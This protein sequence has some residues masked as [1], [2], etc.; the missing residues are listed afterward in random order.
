LEQLTSE[1]QQGLETL[2]DIPLQDFEQ[3]L[4]FYEEV[5]RFEIQLIKRALVFTE[6]HQGNAA[7]LLNLN[8]TTLNAKIKH[9]H[10]QP[11]LHQGN[12]TIAKVETRGSKPGGP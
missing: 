10:I 2:H 3:G 6:G 5:S 8:A 1:L 12:R 11:V 7:R 4:D 9:Y